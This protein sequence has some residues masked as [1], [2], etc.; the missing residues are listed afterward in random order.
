MKIQFAEPLVQKIMDIARG[1]NE[2][3]GD[4]NLGTVEVN[5]IRIRVRLRVS[6][7]RDS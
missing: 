6:Q 1:I 7:L 4:V 5:P 3:V 2:I